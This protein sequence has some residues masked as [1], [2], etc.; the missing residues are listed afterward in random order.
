[1][2]EKKAVI[3]DGAGPGD[4]DLVPVLNVLSHVLEAGGAQVETFALRDMKLAHCLGCF[5]CWLKTPGVCV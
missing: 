2:P 4:G 3:L 1:V 5:D